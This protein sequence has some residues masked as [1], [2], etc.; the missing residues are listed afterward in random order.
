MNYE[1]EVQMHGHAVSINEYEASSRSW[2]AKSLQA[3]EKFVTNFRTVLQSLR[4]KWRQ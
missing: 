1:S 3:K 2:Q 4:L